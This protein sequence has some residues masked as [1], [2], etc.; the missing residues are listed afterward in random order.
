MSAMVLRNSSHH[1]PG[2]FLAGVL[3]LLVHAAFVVFMFF[4]LNWKSQV[5]EGMVVDLWH[6][7]P[8]PVQPVIKQS[9]VKTEP[10][11]PK[12]AEQPAQEKS[13]PPKIASP[14]P[15]KKP[16]IVRKEKK[17]E[18]EP[19]VAEKEPVQEMPKENEQERQREKEKEEEKQREKEKA[20]KAE[21]QRLEREQ[22]LQQQR[23]QEALA[24]AQ[25]E[26]QQAAERARIMN[27]IAKYKA[28]ILAKVRSRIVM[29]P[30]LP[31]NP[32][33][34]FSVTL[35]PGGDILDVQLRK[36]SG[37]TSFDSAV[38]R[39]IFLSK[40]LPLPPNPALFREFRNLN[41]TVHY[42]E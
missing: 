7:L 39:A 12:T 29:P 20:E 3:A 1:E 26:A 40:P 21:A 42:H 13:L 2:K 37:Y 33:T 15:P 25:Y 36:P 32:M 28:M 41:I 19:P 27:E 35:L 16:E 31:G 30:D 4:G 17:E 22:A 6:D 8:Q 38:E 5:P 11:Q 23:E 10:S 18:P 9:L 34:E 14:S 24:A